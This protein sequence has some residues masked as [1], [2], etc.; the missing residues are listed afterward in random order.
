MLQGHTIDTPPPDQHYVTWPLSSE[1]ST[2]ISYQA[3]CSELLVLVQEKVED[4][5]FGC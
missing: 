5:K 2:P 3:L 4:L 1:N